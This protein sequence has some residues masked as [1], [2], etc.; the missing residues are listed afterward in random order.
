MKKIISKYS[1][2][3]L[4]L[5]LVLGFL[6]RVNNLNTWPR[7]G[8][9][10]DEYAWTWQGMNL[11][12]KGVPISWSPHAQYTN[13]KDVTYQKTHFRIVKPFLE[14]P[15]VF[16]LVAGGFAILN[17]VHDMYHLD[18]NH[19]RPLAVILGI[20]SIVFLY[21]LVSEIY[22][23]KTALFAS[24]L[25]AT[26]PTI[27]VGSRIVQNENFFIP[28]W[29]LSLWFIAKYIKSKNVIFRN[30]AA[31]LCC[32]LILAKIPWI[33][34]AGSMFLIFMYLRRWKDA[35]IFFFV[36]IVS[37]LIYFAYGFFY[38]PKL[39]LSLWGLQL[40]RYDIS[41]TS[42]YALFQK[43]FLVDRFMTDGWIYF[44]WFAY[45]LLLLRD[46]KKNYIVIFALLSYFVIFLAGI[47]DEPGHGWYRYPFYPFLVISIALFIKDNFAKNWILTF[48]FLVIVG[49]TLLGLTWESAFG[50]SY[51]V[52]R[53]V[54]ISWGL[55][56]L[57]VFIPGKKAEYVSRISSFIF[58]GTF[59]LMNIWAVLIYNEQ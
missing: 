37:L 23:T 5:I 12:Q 21:L 59:I 10:F 40:N 53:L 19:I 18:I 39:F 42:I 38:D 57:P 41:F 46:F 51:F 26:I 27:V 16:G 20:L 15:P 4:F 30:S 24:L 45:V 47:P 50:F 32:L 49:T 58:L 33:A 43:P 56:L 31:I 44:G 52:F 36:P 34:A 17:G 9:T 22:G 11:I 14:H 2:V 8:A 54:I 1:I 6:L 13:A 48:L 35:A 25:Y 55:T 3:S 29:L 7:L 28:M